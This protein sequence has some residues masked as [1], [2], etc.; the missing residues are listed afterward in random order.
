[1]KKTKHTPDFVQCVGHVNGFEVNH[2]YELTKKIPGAGEQW[3]KNTKG[4]FVKYDKKLFKRIKGTTFPMCTKVSYEV[5]IPAHLGAWV[6][7][8]ILSIDYSRSTMI[9]QGSFGEN[10]MLVNIHTLD[11][12]KTL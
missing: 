8:K 11:L 10:K 7:Y 9:I 3:V 12:I 2:I 6:S 5:K 4:L 1:M